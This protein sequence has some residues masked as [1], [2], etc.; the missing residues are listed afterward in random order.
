M[1]PQCSHNTK[2]RGVY[3][4]RRLIPK[5]P[6]REVA[7]SLR[8]R[9][10]RVAECLATEL[11][12]EFRRLTKDVTTGDKIDLTAILRKHLK[13]SSIVWR[14]VKTVTTPTP[15][16]VIRLRVVS[17]DFANWRTS[18]SN[19]LCC[20]Q[21]CSWIDTLGDLASGYSQG[22]GRHQAVEPICNPRRPTCVAGSRIEQAMAVT[23]WNRPAYGRCREFVVYLSGGDHEGRETCSNK[24]DAFR[25]CT[26]KSLS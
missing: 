12:Q 22:R 13:G 19:L 14:K 18:S 2:K 17:S 9:I 8:T 10:F 7:L 25:R 3:Y 20:L 26:S 5:C 24:P 16:T 4:Y 23:S 6:N 11:D 15:G 1:L 21:I